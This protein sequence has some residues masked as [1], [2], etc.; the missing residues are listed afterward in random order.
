MSIILTC[1]IFWV[2]TIFIALPIGIKVPQM[3]Q[4]GHADS[5]PDKHYVGLKLLITFLISAI[6][7]AI[8]WYVVD[9]LKI[10]FI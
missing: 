8:Y 3:Q 7:T 10:T 5:A 6:L 9:V 4:K 2:I 1:V